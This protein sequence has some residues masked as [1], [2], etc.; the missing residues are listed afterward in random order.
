MDELTKKQRGFVKDYVETGNGV[1]AALN[2]YDTDDYNTANAIAVENLQKPAIQNAILSIAEQIPDS[3]LVEKHNALLKKI[4]DKGD[5][6][7]QAVKAGLEMAY[8]LKGVYAPEKSMN[9]NV[10]VDITN[11]EAVRLAKEYEEKLKDNL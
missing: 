4:D 1:K 3:L 11:P 5:I 2:N 10:D 6:D 9:L 8:K 7:T